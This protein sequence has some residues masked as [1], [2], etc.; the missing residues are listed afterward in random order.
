MKLQLLAAAASVA[1]LAAPSL[2]SAND[3]GWYVRGNVGYGV[4][5]DVDFTGDL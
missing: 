4:V 3:Q 2:A 1:L 5:T